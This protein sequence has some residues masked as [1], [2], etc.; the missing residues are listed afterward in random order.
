MDIRFA[1]LFVIPVILASGCIGAG[2]PP[3]TDSFPTITRE[4]ANGFCYHGCFENITISPDL[5]VEYYN[6]INDTNWE[7]KTGNI[8][9]TKMVELNGEFSRIRFTSMNDAYLV[10]ND[11][12]TDGG[13]YTFHYAVGAV[14]NTVSYYRPCSV[15]S[16]TFDRIN[17]ELDA[18]E[19]TLV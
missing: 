5:R 10:C 3:T 9:R 11:A 18:I 19:K 8:N 14:N 2:F 13:S 16:A 1:I 15:P 6:K 4:Y 7:H 12:P 17:K